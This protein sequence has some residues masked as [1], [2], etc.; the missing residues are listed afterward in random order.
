MYYSNSISCISWIPRAWRPKNLTQ[1]S[2][3]SKVWECMQ[4][5]TVHMLHGKLQNDAR[6]TKKEHMRSEIS[7]AKRH[8]S[9]W[10]E[11]RWGRIRAGGVRSRY[12][13]LAKWQGSVWGEEEQ[14]TASLFPPNSLSHP[15]RRTTP[16]I[17][18]FTMLHD[19]GDV[20]YQLNEM[21]CRH[22][23]CHTAC[24]K[25]WIFIQEFC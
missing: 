1:T 3:I 4:Q 15:F 13:E 12:R 18:T 20:G 21:K 19:A 9:Q 5:R 22:W 6:K 16:L 11:R 23:Y 14:W 17:Q 7:R 8:P 25:K 10:K 2:I 24:R